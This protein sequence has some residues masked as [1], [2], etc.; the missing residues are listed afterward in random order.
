VRTD[1]YKYVEYSTGDR[2]LYDLR[3]DPDELASVHA[4]L[5]YART[6]AALQRELKRLRRCSGEACRRDAGGIPSPGGDI[7]R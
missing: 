7:N 5:R 3:R 2:E 4:D 6:M 1:R